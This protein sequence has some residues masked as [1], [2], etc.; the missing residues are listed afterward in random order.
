MQLYRIQIRSSL[1]R[2]VSQHLTWSWR[3][4]INIHNA[5][6]RVKWEYFGE[7][8]LVI[9]SMMTSCNGNAYRITGHLWIHWSLVDTLHKGPVTRNFFCLML[10]L[11]TIRWTTGRGVGGL[12][13]QNTHVTSLQSRLLWQISG[14]GYWNARQNLMKS[15]V[16]WQVE[17]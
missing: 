8:L 16:T 1:Y 13:H 7:L 5:K 2:H 14:G 15:C 4:I 10:V 11:S 9:T 6:Y 17:Q 3:C 12:R